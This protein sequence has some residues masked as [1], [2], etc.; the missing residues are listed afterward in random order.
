VYYIP[1]LSRASLCVSWAFLLYSYSQLL[2]VLYFVGHCSL[3]GFFVKDYDDDDDDVIFVSS[4]PAV[5]LLTATL[6]TQ[7]TSQ[8]RPT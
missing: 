1:R 6:F 4:S 3:S 8:A 5:G 2:S 7:D